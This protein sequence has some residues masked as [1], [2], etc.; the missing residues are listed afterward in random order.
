M[1]IDYLPPLLEDEFYH[2]YNRG[3]NGIVIFYEERNYGYFLKKLYHYL[4]EYID[5]Y[6]YCLLPNHFHFLIR[7]RIF[8]QSL[9]I[10]GAYRKD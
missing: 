2:I 4:G 9:V 5:I 7:I 10:T 8:H 3:N 1:S 6:A